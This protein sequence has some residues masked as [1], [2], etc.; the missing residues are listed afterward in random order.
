[1]AVV[2]PFAF[3]A[4]NVYVVVAVGVTVAE[5]LPAETEPGAGE[6]LA[7]VAPV[8]TQESVDDW[9]AETLDGVA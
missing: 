5:P 1:V 3:V 6:M 2:L 8:I 4:V 9:P 7:D